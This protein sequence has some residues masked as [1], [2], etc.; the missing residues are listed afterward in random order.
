MPGRLPWGEPGEGRGLLPLLGNQDCDHDIKNKSP[1]RPRSHG[2]EGE[3]IDYCQLFW[4]VGAEE[5][6]VLSGAAKALEL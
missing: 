5:G 6:D 4:G 3:I 1:I 2:Q